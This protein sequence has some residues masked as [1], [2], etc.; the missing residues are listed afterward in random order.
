MFFT[1]VKRFP[2]AL[3]YETVACLVSEALVWRTVTATF[4]DS[5]R[6][7]SDCRRIVF[8]G[9][10][11]LILFTKRLVNDYSSEEST[12]ALVVDYDTDITTTTVLKANEPPAILY[13]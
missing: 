8:P 9:I 13:I 10:P 1:L 11:Y 7:T 5:V 12:A 3:V 2:D 6:R 4:S